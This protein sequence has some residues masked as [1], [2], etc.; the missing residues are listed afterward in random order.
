MT[1]PELCLIVAPHP[2]DE[3]IGSAIWMKR[4]GAKH[5]ILLHIT[6]GSPRDF[7]D[8]Q[9]AGFETRESYAAARRHE[10]RTATAMLGVLPEQCVE[11]HFVDRE[12][13]LNLPDVISRVTDLIDRTRPA[14]VFAPS[15]EGGHPDHDAAALAIALARARSRQLFHHV[16]YRLY[17]ARPDGDVETKAFLPC[18]NAPELILHA[19]PAERA[20]KSRMLESFKSQ[21]KVLSQFDVSE[22]RFRDAPAYDFRHPPHE[23]R[24]LYERWGWG[25]SGAEWCARACECL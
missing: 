10:L 6:D 17:H 25:I 4:R 22:E 2:D 8:A 14:I 20:L 24:L 9:E 16:E 18:A 1:D 5:L 19:S 23:G 3:T 12:V 15:Y 7:S 21:H 11:F 13:Y